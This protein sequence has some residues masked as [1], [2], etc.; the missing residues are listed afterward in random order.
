MFIHV[1]FFVPFVDN[2]VLF[3]CFVFFSSVNDDI[4]K[5]EVYSKTGYEWNNIGYI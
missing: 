2:D 1:V 3:F 5:N 4:N